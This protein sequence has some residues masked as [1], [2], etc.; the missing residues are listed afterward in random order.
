MRKRSRDLGLCADEFLVCYDYG[1]GGLWGILVAPSEDAIRAKYPEL[2]IVGERPKWM[3]DE[4]LDRF[5]AEPLQL[6]D[7]PTG[8][9][10]A[11]MA[12][13]DKT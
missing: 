7:E 2:A 3:A 8:L 9:L 13:R 4:E 6:D 12:D 11:L 10:L 5:H 1:M